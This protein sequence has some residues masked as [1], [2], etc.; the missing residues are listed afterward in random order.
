MHRPIRDF[1]MIS[2]SISISLGSMPVRVR[3]HSLSESV[4]RHAAQLQPVRSAGL[5]HT[6][7]ILEQLDH[8]VWLKR[9]LGERHEGQ[10]G[11]MPVCVPRSLPRLSPLVCPDRPVHVS[12]TSWHLE[13]SG[14]LCHLCRGFW[15]FLWS[16]SFTASVSPPIWQ[17]FLILSGLRTGTGNLLVP[18][19]RG[20][21]QFNV[22][23]RTK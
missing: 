10:P 5:L 20:W 17:T 23:P 18:C 13:A 8:L 16:W 11:S 6:I 3:R 1:A 12:S 14:S 9:I 2:I 19:G 7:N 22:L 15:G 21:M 4:S